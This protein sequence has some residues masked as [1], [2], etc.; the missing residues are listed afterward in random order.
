MFSPSHRL[1]PLA[2]ASLL[3]VT[4]CDGTSSSPPT[5]VAPQAPAGMPA[6]HPGMDASAGAAAG[7]NPH[8]DIGTE[9]TAP[10][11]PVKDIPKAEGEQGRT[12]AEVFGQRADLSGKTVAVRGQVVKVNHGIMG[13]NWLHIQDGS[14]SAEGADQDLAITTDGDANLGDVVTVTGVLGTD[15]DFGAGYTYTAIIES[16]T[17]TPQ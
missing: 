15:R 10:V 9:T 3:L 13:H 6:N 17:V 8:A 1:A 16:A 7:T 12:V 4:A 5:D 2:L 11:T 14:G